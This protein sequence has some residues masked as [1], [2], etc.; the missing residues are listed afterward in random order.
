MIFV[1]VIG[2][3]LG[4]KAPKKVWISVIIALI[5]MYFLC[6]NGEAGINK[7]DFL[8]LICSLGFALHILVIDYFSPKVNAI[9]TVSYTHL[10]VY[11]RQLLSFCQP[12]FYV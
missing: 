6:M 9:K 4:R 10:D 8:V 1:P 7:G 11:K 12:L 2:I 5:G 3:L